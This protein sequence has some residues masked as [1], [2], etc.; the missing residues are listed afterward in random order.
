[1]HLDFKLRFGSVDSNISCHLYHH[2]GL[3]I[4][5]IDL[6]FT[7]ICLPFNGQ[8]F[9]LRL[10]SFTWLWHGGCGRGGGRQARGC[11]RFSSSNGFT[12]SN[13]TFYNII[14][15]RCSHPYQKTNNC[16]VPDDVLTSSKALNAMH[17]SPTTGDD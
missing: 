11:N 13:S 4:T 2:I 5:I 3:P 14:C 17:L 8:T 7:S 16:W 10:S 1:M 12:K 9:Q 6:P 15:C